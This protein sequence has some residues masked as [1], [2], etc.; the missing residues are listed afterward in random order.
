MARK[1]A[2]FERFQR[3]KAVWLGFCLWK[4]DR[5]TSPDDSGAIRKQ[6][7]SIDMSLTTILLIVLVLILIGG[8]STRGYGVGH[9]LNGG[10][11]LLLVILL[12]LYLMGKI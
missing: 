6:P 7:S 10:I 5:L 11:G 12:V 4:N 8:V 3:G 2:T 9:G 1:N